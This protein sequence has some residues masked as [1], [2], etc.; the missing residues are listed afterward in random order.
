MIDG[1][2]SLD[3]RKPFPLISIFTRTFYPVSAL[4]LVLIW[5]EENRLPVPATSNYGRASPLP[6]RASKSLDD[7]VKKVLQE[8]DHSA[9]SDDL[10][11]S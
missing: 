9:G 4:L 1:C 2:Q 11:R 7:C 6:R 10:K 5:N 8:I 3:R